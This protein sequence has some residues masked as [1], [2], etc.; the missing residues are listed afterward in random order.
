MNETSQSAQ[1][2]DGDLERKK[3]QIGGIFP[4]WQRNGLGSMGRTLL[5]QM[6]KRVSSDSQS[7]IPEDTDDVICTGEGHGEAASGV[8]STTMVGLAEGLQVWGE[9]SSCARCQHRS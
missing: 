4:E 8:N 7:G 6:I 5:S 9:G 1:H 3:E 2:N